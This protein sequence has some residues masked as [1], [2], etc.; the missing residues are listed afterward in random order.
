ME[1][2]TKDLRRGDCLLG[3]VLHL[4]RS[5][6]YSPEQQFC[7]MVRLVAPKAIPLQFYCLP[8]NDPM[9]GQKIKVKNYCLIALWSLDFLYECIELP[10]YFRCSLVFN[11]PASK[12]C[13][14]LPMGQTWP[15]VFNLR[16][17]TILEDASTESPV[18]CR[19]GSLPWHNVLGNGMQC[20]RFKST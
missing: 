3:E 20:C 7:Q 5:I 6:W 9:A 16:F 14:Y 17:N 8:T 1:T 18:K 11:I 10:T 19:P 15:N 13:P 12:H 2:K 4:D